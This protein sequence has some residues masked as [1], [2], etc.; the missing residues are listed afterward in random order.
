[1]TEQNLST[2]TANNNG[3]KSN[4]ISS[5]ISV[6]KVRKYDFDVEEKPAIRTT[7]SRIYMWDKW[8]NRETWENRDGAYGKYFDTRE[9]A[10]AH[11]KERTESQ[12]KYKQE[13]I[14]KLQGA[15]AKL[16]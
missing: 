9:E 14:E 5:S 15:L 1:M 11:I 2:E 7:T 16:K 12:I 3:V 13:E 6:F 10:I 8:R 4:V